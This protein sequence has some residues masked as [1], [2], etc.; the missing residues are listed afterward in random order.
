MKN[1]HYYL[2]PLLLVGFLNVS[3]M[4]SLSRNYSDEEAGK[5]EREDEDLTLSPLSP[6]LKKNKLEPAEKRPHQA[7]QV[8]AFLLKLDE[9]ETRTHEFI[10]RLKLQKLLYYVQGYS[11]AINGCPLFTEKI[12]HY[13]YGPVVF[14]VMTLLDKGYDERICLS[15]LQIEALEETTFTKEEKELMK[16]VFKLKMLKSGKTL[17]SDSHKEKPYTSTLWNEE[18]GK[19][20]LESFFR[21]LDLWVPYMIH[22]FCSAATNEE[23]ENLIR[24]VRAC[25]SYSCLD[26]ISLGSIVESFN[27]RKKDLEKSLEVWSG[28]VAVRWPGQTHYQA[29]IG[30]LFFPVQLEFN[31]EVVRKDSMA[32]RLCISAEHGNALAMCHA[33]EILDLFTLKKAAP[34]AANFKNPLIDFISSFADRED[35]PA[36]FAGLLC[37]ALKKFNKANT[38]FKRGFEQNHAWSGF[39]YIMNLRNREVRQAQITR[40][41]Q[42]DSNLAKLANVSS[43]DD[44]F[45]RAKINQEVGEAG[46]PSGYFNA[47]VL[48][49]DIDPQNAIEMYKLAARS[50]I[51]SA[52]EKL[53]ELYSK[54]EDFASA[55]KICENWIKTG[56]A[57]AF[58]QLGELLITK[59]KKR[60]EG[61]SCFTH[62]A[63]GIRGLEKC[64]EHAETFELRE[65][66]R[67]QLDAAINDRYAYVK[68]KI[69]IA[70]RILMI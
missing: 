8:A 44:L 27:D 19:E 41:T 32:S 51:V 12:I 15:D 14:E 52:Y 4:E 23:F 56:D 57:L 3:A 9:N 37:I 58:V 7:A 25:I 67:Q 63:A 50:H 53:V 64:V 42:L 36:Y 47:G 46:I 54:E 26:N 39:R 70:K 59:E 33:L 31:Y 38:H 2:L 45:Q 24:Y 65:K 68:S 20:L 61:L 21:E 43:E 5:R 49:E 11:L 60:K 17:A 29:F 55:K 62:D 35:C 69:L 1:A 34:D 10:D 6:T 30:H 13:T 18:I 28:V 40:L 16:T 22:R 48:L 66:L